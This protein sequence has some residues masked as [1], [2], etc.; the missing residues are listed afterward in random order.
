M[1]NLPMK[2]LLDIGQEI[3]QYGELANPGLGRAIEEAN[4]ALRVD[5]T[6]IG[7]RSMEKTLLVHLSAME[8]MSY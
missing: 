6:V 5:C 3:E 4:R 7:F 1:K 8:Q 2:V